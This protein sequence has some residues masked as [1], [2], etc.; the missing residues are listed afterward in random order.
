MLCEHHYSIIQA[1]A[2]FWLSPSFSYCW[3]FRVLCIFY[4]TVLYQMCFLQIF[5]SSLWQVFSFP[6]KM[7]SHCLSQ[8]LQ[9]KNES[10]NSL[11]LLNLKT[12]N[13]S[14]RIQSHTTTYN[15]SL[16]SD[17]PRRFKP[18]RAL[19]WSLT[20]S[21][22]GFLLKTTFS[23]CF[24]LPLSIA[25]ESNYSIIGRPGGN[26]SNL[27]VHLSLRDS[28]NLSFKDTAWKLVSCFSNLCLL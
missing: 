5:S 13:S 9:V 24:K 1:F 19:L 12:Q 20:I 18:R 26:L 17:S 4:I 2:H 10:G 25:L 23:S 11:S 7:F 28:R 21:S 6:R 22:S 8:F 3:L 27:A 16:V 15:F 14:L